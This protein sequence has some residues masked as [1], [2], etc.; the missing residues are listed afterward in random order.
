MGV[1]K[2]RMTE[3]I[4]AAEAIRA[5]WD[6]DPSKEAENGELLVHWLQLRCFNPIFGITK[7]E[8]KSFGIPAAIVKQAHLTNYRMAHRP[9]GTK[10][11]G[12][13]VVNYVLRSVLTSVSGAKTA[14][15]LKEHGFVSFEDVLPAF[16]LYYSSLGIKLENIKFFQK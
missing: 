15:L 1:T 10:K 14:G 8:K 5:G 12:T 11:T 7:E 2:E 3:C 6:A 13:E 4:L 9:N 16:I